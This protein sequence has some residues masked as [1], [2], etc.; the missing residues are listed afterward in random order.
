LV[1]V[2]VALEVTAL[3]IFHQSFPEAGAVEV[4]ELV[5]DAAGDGGAAHLQN[6]RHL[7]FEVVHQPAL[8]HDDF[9]KEIGKYVRCPPILAILEVTVT[10]Y[11]HYEKQQTIIHLKNNRWMKSIC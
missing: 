8:C 9:I 10:L 7:V 11:F 2:Q 4:V 6:L 5:G 1:V 3:E